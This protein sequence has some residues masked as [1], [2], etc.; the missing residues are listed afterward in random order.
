MSVTN[1]TAAPAVP[2]QRAP[3]Q[4]LMVMDDGHMVPSGPSDH[5]GDDK[6]KF[7]DLVALINPLQHLP[8]I[9]PLYRKLT[10]DEPHP[11]VKVVGGLIFGG[12]MGLMNATLNHVFEQTTGK[13]MVEAVA[14]L[15]SADG[16]NPAIADAA[17]TANASGAPRRLI[18]AASASTPEPAAVSA[19]MPAPAQAAAGATPT[20]S[21]AA[22]TPTATPAQAATN[23]TN[24][25]APLAARQ[26]G[27]RDLA[28]YQLNAGARMP[29]T[30]NG[31]TATGSQGPS[32]PRSVGPS[33]IQG[34][35]SQGSTA[36]GSTAQGSRTQGSIGQGS[37]A[38]GSAAQGATNQGSINRGSTAQG[39]A[40]AALSGASSSPFATPPISAAEFLSRAATAQQRYTALMQQAARGNAAV[41]RLE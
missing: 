9:G 15:F 10:G 29:A 8:V 24:N 35:T 11:A 32:V 25:A 3:P 14:G 40:A 30:L 16:E 12:P 34:A 5:S 21:I 31:S 19:P 2:I 27:A 4:P 22:A 13:T 36:Q 33:Y 41:D 28:W 37:T 26:A 20:P 1:A 38:Q 18:P 17:E 23:A 7:S 6:F 39:S